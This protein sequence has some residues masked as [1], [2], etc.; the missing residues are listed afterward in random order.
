[1]APVYALMHTQIKAAQEPRADSPFIFYSRFV[2]LSLSF[3][4]LFRAAAA[5]AAAIV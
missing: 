1:M 3:Q 4:K 5:A 2:S